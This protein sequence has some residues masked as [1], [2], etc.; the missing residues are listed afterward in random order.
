MPINIPADLP[1]RSKLEQENIFVMSN[2]KA[3]VQDIRPLQIA[4][5][6]LMPTK[7]AT[8]TQLLRLLGNSPVQVD[9]TLIRAEHHVSKNTSADHLERFYTTCS[10]LKNR[11]FDG[12]IITGAPVE[13]L[14]FSE[15]DYWDELTAIMDYSRSNVFSTL[16]ICWG[17]QAGLFH[18]FGIEKRPL[19][20]KIFGVYPHRVNDRLNPIFRGFD[21]MFFMPHSRYTETRKADIET[22][23]GLQILAESPE[24]GAVIIKDR[25]R[26]QF[27]IT[28]H[29][30]YD[31]NT[32]DREYRRDKER[33]LPISIPRHYYPDDNPE[34]PPF[35]SWRAHANLFFSN[36]MNFYVYQETPFELD[37][38]G[39][40]ASGKNGI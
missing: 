14:A 3:L 16:Y 27:F 4:V 30:E 35:V 36:W 25:L 5:V 2:D 32:L 17:A 26:R 12:M 21:D 24:T 33:G 9:I 37:A 10:K 34:K 8:E 23:P 40:D 29:M 1:A 13:Q 19:P 11:K 28:G 7:I 18:H 6:N 22:C 39:P 38:I 31:A 20:E 15:V